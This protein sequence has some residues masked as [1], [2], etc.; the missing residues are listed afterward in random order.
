M[1]SRAPFINKRVCWTCASLLT[2]FVGVFPLS[3]A[4]TNA[5]APAAPPLTP[6]DM[7]EGGKD[8]YNNWLELSAGGF[9]T[10]GDKAQFQQRQ[11]SRGGPFGGIEDFHYQT[12]VATNTTLSVD[13]RALF[14]NHDYK[15][16]LDLAREKLGYLLFSYNEFRTWYNGDGGFDP[17]SNMWYPLSQNP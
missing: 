3:A 9:L 13:G 11:R 15:L 8:A 17:L 1:K 2:A 6:Q 10:G 12:S 5:P 7:F 16:R 4:D 14:D